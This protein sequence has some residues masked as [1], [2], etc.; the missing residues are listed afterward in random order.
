MAARI[1]EVQA[2]SG[3][4]GVLLEDV[5][6]SNLG[7]TLFYHGSM[8]VSDVIEAI[9]D[10]LRPDNMTVAMRVLKEALA[11][12]RIGKLSREEF[13]FRVGTALIRLAAG[14]SPLAIGSVGE[15]LA[16][17]RRRLILCRRTSPLR[18]RHMGARGS[19]S[20]G[21]DVDGSALSN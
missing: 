12:F 9:K 15:L 2:D 1:A 11:A 18:R 6:R 13:H 5:G 8:S 10:H 7:R 20:S 14:R 17:F 4:L 3:K 21:T 16:R 19:P